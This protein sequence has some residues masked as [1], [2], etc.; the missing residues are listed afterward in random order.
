M[1]IANWVRKYQLAI[2]GTLLTG[3]GA[4]GVWL[5]TNSVGNK[6][7]EALLIAGVLSLTVDVY[8]KRKLQEDAAKDIFHHLLGL[9][10]PGEI[11]EALKNIVFQA[12][13]Y[14]TDMD[15]RVNAS[16]SGQAVLLDV[17]VRTRVKAASRTDYSQLIQFEESEHP[18]LIIASATS[19]TKPKSSYSISNPPLNAKRG[20][21]EVLE[22]AG[23]KITLSRGDE[24]QT[25]AKYSVKR[26]LDDF[27]VLFFG[28][29]TIGAHV[30]VNADDGLQIT[31]SLADQVNGDEHIY[32]KVF[33]TGDHIQVRWKPK[34]TTE[35]A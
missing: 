13:R 17:D 18:Q 19:T 12:R 22:W 10:L 31:A 6:L 26:G 16:I 14:R 9:D 33:I 11:R 8:L 30:R 4:L 34:A 3:A 5:C 2:I 27:W 35:S 23:N 29:P 25:F 28:E 20:E 15:V 1:N 24:L 32:T 7:S 21:P